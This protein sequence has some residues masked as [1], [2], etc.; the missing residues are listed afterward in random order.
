MRSGW[1][2]N[3]LYKKMD[4]RSHHCTILIIPFNFFVS[5]NLSRVR[6]ELNYKFIR[7]LNQRERE[8]EREGMENRKWWIRE[9]MWDCILCFLTEQRYEGKKVQ[10]NGSHCLSVLGLIKDL[11]TANF[12]DNMDERLI[13][14]TWRH[15]H[16]LIC[17][18]CKNT[19]A[20]TAMCDDRNI[21]NHIQPSK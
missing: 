9:T 3:S 19:S 4:T 16:I 14:K 21:Q 5:G 13:F 20:L 18:E 1:T 17:V 11:S 2:K 12:G 10:F 15:I 6:A 7:T 8:R